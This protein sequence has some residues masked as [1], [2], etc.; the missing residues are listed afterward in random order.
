[1]KWLIHWLVSTVAVLVVAYVLPGVEVAGFWTAFVVA[2]ALG[3]VN[4]ILKP[5]LVLL[6]LPITILTLGLFTLIINAVLVLLVSSF[7]PGFTVAGF[8]WALA[9]SVILSLTSSVLY[10]FEH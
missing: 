9:F 5:V 10:S 2:V 3:L 4:M 8:G 1:M 6:T 7:V